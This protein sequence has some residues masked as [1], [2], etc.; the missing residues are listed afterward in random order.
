MTQITAENIAQIEAHFDEVK[1]RM[2]AEGLDG[3]EYVALSREYAELEPVAK[4]AA[5]VRR[6]RAEL[7]VIKGLAADPDFLPGNCRHGQ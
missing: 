2:S 1:A 3:E 7:L 6:L 5:E 4:A